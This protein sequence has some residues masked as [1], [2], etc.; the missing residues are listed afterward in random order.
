MKKSPIFTLLLASGLDG[1]FGEPPTAVHPVICMGNWLS[2]GRKHAPNG[3]ATRFLFGAVWVL[4]GMLLSSMAGWI[5]QRVLGEG[6]ALWCVVAWRSLWDASG[7]VEAALLADDLPE[8]RRLLA[9]HLVSRDT[10]SLSESEIAESAIESV[11]ENLTDSWVAPLLAYAWGGV[12]LAWAYRFLNTADAMWGY[13]DEEREWLGKTAALLDDAANWLP[14]RVAAFL[15]MLLGGPHAAQT[16]W[17]E[18]HQT[19]S[20]NGGWTMAAMAGALHTTLRKPGVYA[21]RGGDTPA[22]GAMIGQAR[23]LLT[24]ACALT[25]G[26]VAW[27]MAKS[28]RY[29]S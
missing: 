5:A 22:D 28:G 21:L 15:L 25:V 8:A 18:Q 24:G 16:A 10:T 6:V 11:A 14:A 13:R 4:I 2:W 7:E 3:E 9:W 17:R 27:L 29:E 26:L 19:P 23:K 1:L 20:P 12:P